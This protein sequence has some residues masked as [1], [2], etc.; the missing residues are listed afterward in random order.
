MSNI[1][2]RNNVVYVRFASSAINRL[3]VARLVTFAWGTYFFGSEA[4]HEA[5]ASSASRVSQVSYRRGAD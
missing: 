1:S 3:A 5:C 4:L 2:A